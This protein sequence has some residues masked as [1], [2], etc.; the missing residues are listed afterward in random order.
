MPAGWAGL[1]A[2]TCRR[3]RRRPSPPRRRS[4]ST[5]PW[6]VGAGGS[7]L[8]ARSRA[9]R[10][11]SP[12]VAGGALR[13]GRVQPQG[14]RALQLLQPL[15]GTPWD[16]SPAPIL[17]FHAGL[18]P[19]HNAL[20]PPWSRRPGSCSATAR[21]GRC[22]LW[23]TSSL[24]TCWRRTATSPS[25]PAEAAAAAAASAW[26][27]RDAS[28]AGGPA[29]RLWGCWRRQQPAAAAAAAACWAAVDSAARPVHLE[30][31]RRPCVLR[32]GG[33]GGG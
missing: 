17:C 12:V 6:W 3:P 10:V 32:A 21:R 30:A 25:P 11:C 15:P 22:A 23:L 14:Q 26:R 24:A 8:A 31:R 19:R 4:S 29:R 1:A 13:G 27:A 20:R 7:A 33:A 16:R 9:L 28:A 18:A 5:C 2:S